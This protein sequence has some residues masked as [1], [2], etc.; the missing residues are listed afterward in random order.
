MADEEDQGNDESDVPSAPTGWKAPATPEELNS[1]IAKRVSR[2]EAK[3][4]DY[5]ALR[6]K[7]ARAEALDDELASDKEKAVKAATTETEARVRSEYVPQLVRTAFRAEAKGVLTKEQLAELLEDVDLSRFVTD[8]GEVD[9]ERIARKVKALAP[10]QD[11]DEP[12]QRFPDL[13]GGNRGKAST[14]TNMNSLIRQR[15]GLGK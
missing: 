13:G 8:K 7:A 2:V 10:K 1:I 14:A 5:E 3:Y 15:A 9:E 4:K 6:E 11:D 12:R